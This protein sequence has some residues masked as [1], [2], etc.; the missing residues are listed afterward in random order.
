MTVSRMKPS[1]RDSSVM[2]LTAASA[3]SK[4]MA[5]RA[6]SATNR[7]N[8]CFFLIKGRKARIIA[9]FF[10]APVCGVIMANIASAR[11][12]ARQSEKRR[13]HNASLRSELRS[14]IKRVRKA[15]ED[16][17]K[18]AGARDAARIDQ[19]ARFDRR[20]ENHSQ[21]QSLAPQEPLVR[22]NQGHG[23]TSLAGSPALIPP[24]RA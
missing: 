6:A 18:A 11:K 19:V 13:Q 21:E 10:T 2:L 9:P 14:A 5:E 12:A 3:L 17:D 22:R 20:Q 15:I 7:L 24:V 8:R 4:F 16:G 1:I 23:V